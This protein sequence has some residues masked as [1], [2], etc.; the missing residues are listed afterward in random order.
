MDDGK[1][2]LDVVPKAGKK[3]FITK[4]M[5]EACGFSLPLHKEYVQMNLKT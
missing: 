3:G 1:K 2:C 4:K 5:T